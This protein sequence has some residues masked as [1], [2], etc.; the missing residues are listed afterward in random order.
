MADR[1]LANQQAVGYF[2]VLDPL[3]YERD[4]LKLALGKGRDLLCFGVGLPGFADE[5]P[6]LSA[7]A[8]RRIEPRL[9]FV[10]AFDR[11]NQ[12]SGGFLF[13]DYPHRSQQ[14][15]LPMRFRIAQAGQYDYSGLAG[16]GPQL[17]DQC[18][19]A[20]PAKIEVKKNDLGL[21]RGS[22]R[23]RVIAAPRLT[24]DS[25]RWAAL[26]DH[27]QP[28]PDDRMIINQKYSYRLRFLISIRSSE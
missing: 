14:D 22:Q 1:S 28:G 15:S 13:F 27:A 9:A 12:D 4:H 6:R 18:H 10:Y 23:Q 19:P 5:S 8:M 20:V 2:L 26:D 17:S 24:N 21:L 3:T 25:H 16:R 11:R 7:P